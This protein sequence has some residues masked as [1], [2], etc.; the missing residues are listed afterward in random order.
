M[1]TIYGIEMLHIHWIFPD[2]RILVT[3]SLE[4][5]F[6]NGFGKSYSELEVCLFVCFLLIALELQTD[7]L[8]Y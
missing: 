2:N 1:D 5:I 7:N 6:K 4:Q 8:P 3:I